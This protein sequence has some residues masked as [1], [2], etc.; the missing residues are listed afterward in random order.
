MPKTIT[1]ELSDRQLQL[2]RELRAHKAGIVPDDKVEHLTLK[3]AIEDVDTI[4]AKNNG[5]TGG[6]SRDNAIVIALGTGYET[7]EEG[8]LDLVFKAVD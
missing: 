4:A 6:F 3:E 7:T 8:I 2:I 1:L 5:R